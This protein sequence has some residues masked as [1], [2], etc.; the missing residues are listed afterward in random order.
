MTAASFL[1][2]AALQR[3][4]AVIS[5]LLVLSL[6]SQVLYGIYLGVRRGLSVRSELQSA[7]EGGKQISA[8]IGTATAS[9]TFRARPGLVE[10]AGCAAGERISHVLRSHLRGLGS[11][12]TGPRA[13]HGRRNS[14]ADLLAA[15]VESR[16]AFLTSPA[17]ASCEDTC[18]SAGDMVCVELWFRS[19]NNCEVLAAAFPDRKQCIVGV[20][21]G[22]DAPGFRP[23]DETTI[24]NSAAKLFPS[25]CQSRHNSTQRLCGC[26]RAQSLHTVYSVQPTPY[27]KWQV[28]WLHHSFRQ[29]QMRGDIT[30]LLTAEAADELTHIPTHVSRPMH[31][32]NDSYSPINKPY[33]LVQWLAHAKPTADA[34]LV[35][36]PD[37]IF[38]QRLDHTVQQGTALGQQAYFNFDFADGEAQDNLA[39]QVARRYCKGCRLA[40]GSLDPVAVPILIHRKDLDKL[41]PR[42]LEKTLEM[43]RFV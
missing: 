29:V 1:R 35:I 5:T 34:I 20:F 33:A 6:L 11:S 31:T 12:R 17:G 24:V 43:R 9:R 4:R 13:V 36:D 21:A 7:G 16:S 23:R 26:E 10:C 25:S 2:S 32:G 18:R 40:R 38:V 37:C 22:G 42:W 41:A 14:R 15:I 8:G 30:R 39:A 27:F 3:L 19:L 28:K